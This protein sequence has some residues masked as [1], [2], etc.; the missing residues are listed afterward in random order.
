MQHFLSTG[1][2]T[3]PH[4]YVRVAGG[5]KAKILMKMESKLE[6]IPFFLDE[7]AQYC[8]MAILPK[9]ISICPTI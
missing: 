9:L 6:D 4:S 1:F 7:K 5:E 2:L 8:G 3:T